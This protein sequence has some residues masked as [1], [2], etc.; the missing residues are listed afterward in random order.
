MRFALAAALMVVSV[1]NVASVLIACGDKYL[2]P[3]RATRYSTPPPKREPASLLV[4]ASTSSEMARMLARHSVAKTFQKA[5]YRVT[6]TATEPEFANALNQSRWDLVLLDYNDLRLVTGRSGDP[7]ASSLMPISYT[8]TGSQW[9][10]ARQQYPLIVRKPAK[11][12]SWLDAVDAALEE[13]RTARA[14]AQK[15]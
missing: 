8:L 15:R 9:T 1:T 7:T 14:K 5:G 11:A 3:V 2:V 6:E 4:Y 12:Q 10:N 13:T